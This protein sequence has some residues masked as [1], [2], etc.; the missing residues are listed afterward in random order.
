MVDLKANPFYL[1]D[2][3]IA[4]VE[5]TKNQ[6][7]LEE[8]IGQLFCPVGFTT[9]RDVL[10]GMLEKNIGGMMYRPGMGADSG[11]SPF[12]AGKHEDSAA[13]GGQPGIRRYWYS[14]RRY[15]FCQADAGGCLSKRRRAGLPFGLYFLY[16]RSSS[17][18]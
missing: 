4:W 2:E 17:R 12:F 8:K 6:M 3:A 1:D 14:G 16:G 11:H 9:D 10:K 5:E 13:A 15:E 7:T 18:L